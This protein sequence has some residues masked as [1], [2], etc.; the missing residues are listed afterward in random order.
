MADIVSNGSQF[1]TDSTCLVSCKLI[2]LY[3]DERLIPPTRQNQA[4]PNFPSEY[5]VS[6]FD[7]RNGPIDIDVL[8]HRL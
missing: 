6:K 5:D 8:N 1:G 4:V 7:S 2:G 3:L